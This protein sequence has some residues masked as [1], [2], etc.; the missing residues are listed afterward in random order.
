MSNSQIFCNSAW[1]ELHIYWD[2]SYGICCTERHKLYSELGGQYNIANMSI[3]EWFNS[4]PVNR[5]RQQLL[6]DKEISVCQRCYSEEK[7]G[8]ISK[9]IKGNLK[10]AIFMQAFSDSFHQSP[11]HKH[12]TNPYYSGVPIDMHIDLGNHCNLTCKMCDA[13]SSSKI[14]AQEVKWG[15]SSSRP[16]I[17]TNWT[18]DQQVWDNFK[19]QLLD[20]PKLSNIHLMGGETLL[21][22]RF[23]D[24]VD[25]L[26]DH[27][28]FD[29]GFSFVTNGTIYN[30]D[31]V[32]KMSR[33]KRTGI[34]ISIE[35]VTDHN[36]YVRQGTN[37]AQVLD[38]IKK[39]NNLS[40]G[41]TVDV[42]IRPAISALS[43]GSFW[44]LLEYCL[45][46][47]MVMKPNWCIRPE[48]LNPVILPDEIKNQYLRHYIKIADKLKDLDSNRVFNASDHNNSNYIV[49][50]WCNACITSL[51]LPQP[52][53]ANLLLEELVKHCSKWDSLADYSFEKLYPE[54]VPLFEKYGYKKISS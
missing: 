18:A 29:V 23:E 33:F 22:N 11:G 54:L 6:G 50:H 35:S 53:N 2:G 1:Y 40:N 42:T 20:I 39:Y 19:H 17:G 25:F 7:L 36:D 52:D 3:Q 46:Q 51:S 44:T 31:L 24:L 45:E 10:S 41:T 16:F 9:R 4:E 47:N 21:S 49:K 43:I 27:Q 28:R 34:E 38:I 30:P 32:K 15:I 8:A 14:A 26:T 13:K 12:F 5:F 37:T 48:F